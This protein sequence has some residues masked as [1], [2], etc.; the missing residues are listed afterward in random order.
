MTKKTI[1]MAMLAGA[2]LVI[3]IGCNLPLGRS[4]ST[5]QTEPT[6][7]VESL[8]SSTP[9]VESPTSALA[10]PTTD[11]QPTAT[12]QPTAT[13]AL[14]TE[15]VATG[16]A[17]TVLQDLNLRTGPGTAYRPPI[18]AL[19]AQTVVIPTGYNPVG[20][21]GGPWVQ[22]R[23]PGANEVGWVSAGDQFVSC[24]IDL[25]TLPS[26]A[27]PTPAPPPPP[28]ANNSTPDGTFPDNFIWEADFNDRYFVRFNVYDTNS[29]GTADGDGI[30]EVS[31]QVLDGDGNQVYQR[32]ERQSG[33]CIFGGG[34]P[35]CN[36]WVFE[37]NV[38]KW[39]A[40]GELVNNAQYRLLIVVTASS[41]DQGNWN[42]DIDLTLPN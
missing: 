40:G 16:P 21:P 27:V 12:S 28:E 14:P 13:E 8:P 2:A 10:T 37:D 35:D 11:I 42:Y 33:F 5:P 9:P 24:N 32:T 19:P 26:V 3:L 18:R 41:G 29:G 6:G 17:C 23:D 7:T 15:T 1:H 4:P 30:S 39:N 34:E 38:Y 25:T 20:I 36:P 31:F 22:V